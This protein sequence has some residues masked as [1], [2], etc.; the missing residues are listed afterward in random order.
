[1]QP[2]LYLLNSIKYNLFNGEFKIKI[3]FNISSIA[4]KFTIPLPYLSYMV[5]III[6]TKS[7]VNLL[8]YKTVTKIP[9]LTSSSS[10]LHM[11]SHS[12]FLWLYVVTNKL[13]ISS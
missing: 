1:M 4:L 7:A 2:K 12:H 13:K 5:F 6:L 9:T 8:Q 11:I 10:T 3:E